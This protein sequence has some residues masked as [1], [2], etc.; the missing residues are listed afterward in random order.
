MEHAASGLT[1][2][3]S[4]SRASKRARVLDRGEMRSRGAKVESYS[5]AGNRFNRPQRA[6]VEVEHWDEALGG[7]LDPTLI[8]KQ[9]I[10]GVEKQGVWR[11]HGRAGVHVHESFDEC[12]YRETHEEADNEGPLGR[13]SPQESPSSARPINGCAKG[14]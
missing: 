11:Q 1:L 8:V 14:C 10:D 7:K 12:G 6:F 5:G 4:P 3:D 9:L 2:K 13:R